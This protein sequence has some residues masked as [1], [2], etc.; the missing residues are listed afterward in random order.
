MQLLRYHLCFSC[1]FCVSF[2]FLSRSLQLHF[3]PSEAHLLTWNGCEGNAHPE[4]AAILWDLRTGEQLRAFK[5]R[6]PEDDS[7]DMQWSAD[8][9][10]L[11]RLEH[12]STVKTE[13]IKVYDASNNA[14]ALLDKKSLKVPGAV[15]FSWCPATGS[16]NTNL[17]AWWSPERENAP[18]SVQ[19][20][21]FPSRELVRQR[22]L[23]NVETL[24]LAWHPEGA[25]LAVLAS[26]AT[27][28]KTKP[29]KL[30]PL[31]LPTSNA[32]SGTCGWT[33]ELFRLRE[34]DVPVQ[35]LEV[36]EH[37]RGLFWEPSSASGHRFAVVTDHPTVRGHYNISFYDM[38]AEGAA[39]AGSSA[40]AVESTKPT[41]LFT[42][43]EK[44]YNA[45]S[46]SPKGEFAVL[47][48]ASNLTSAG[49][50]EFYDVE[51]RKSLGTA[52]HPNATGHS[53]DPSGR[54]LASYKTSG[55]KGG[56][57]RDEVDNGYRLYS[58][59]GEKLFETLKVKLMRFEWRPRPAS[60]LTEEEVKAV[61]KS[62][63]TYITRFQEEDKKA[64]NRKK[65][66][67]RLYKRKQRDEFRSLLA[68]RH[69]EWDS[70]RAERELLRGRPDYPNP[71]EAALDVIIEETY[72]K[73]V[74][75]KIEMIA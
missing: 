75:E 49:R 57:T 30:A 1:P 11:A 44:P 33:I 28:K 20:L 42:L 59:Q 54:C 7:C 53:W 72:E 61:S 56:L 4:K 6:R 25:Y 3:S 50:Y 38:Q 60:L 22:N 34:K 43:E 39:G 13:L 15:E 65:L 27:K 10:L 17:L 26:K 18:A 29:E 63:R 24:T 23:F 37:V 45:V 67:E 70:R 40:K 74:E 46:W 69:A 73:V 5:Q 32:A 8:G 41:L 12:D 66:L 35:V 48:T 9:K 36:S 64:D 68:A 52:E 31:T 2:P 71:T 62:L 51:R 16:N 47:T 19:V 55:L 21:R 58:F 14:F